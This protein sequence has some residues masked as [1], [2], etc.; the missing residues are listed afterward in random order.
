MNTFAKGANEQK[1]LTYSPVPSTQRRRRTIFGR[2]AVILTDPNPR[3]RGMDEYEWG[4][5]RQRASG[6]I[7]LYV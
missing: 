1:L 4:S 2:G 7:N 5:K 3:L 6:K